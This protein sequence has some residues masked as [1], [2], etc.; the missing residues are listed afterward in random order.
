MRKFLTR[1]RYKVATVFVDHYSCL[2]FAYLQKSTG[3]E[4]TVQA[5]KRAF[6]A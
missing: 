5:M 2:S 3:G 1:Q 6:E 4:E